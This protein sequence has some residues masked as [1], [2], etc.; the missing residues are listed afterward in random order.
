[1]YSE[2]CMGWI[3]FGASRDKFKS[4]Q[5]SSAADRATPSSARR[6]LLMPQQ[7]EGAHPEQ[8]QTDFL[9]GTAIGTTPP[10]VFSNSERTREQFDQIAPL[11]IPAEGKNFSV[12]RTSAD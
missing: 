10:P 8:M 4:F 9:V 12:A 2:S 3:L 1:M 5:P 7:H 6:E 11:A